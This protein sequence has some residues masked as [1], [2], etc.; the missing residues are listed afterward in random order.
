MERKEWLTCANLFYQNREEEAYQLLGQLLPQIQAYLQEL[1]QGA[2]EGNSEH[3]LMH[4]QEFIQAYQGHDQLAIS[5]WLFEES[6]DIQ[7]R[8]IEMS[9]AA[10][11]A[12]GEQLKKNEAILRAKWG[13]YFEQYQALNFEDTDKYKC[14]QTV[15]GTRIMMCLR[16]R[17]YYR[18][19]SMI[20]VDMAA[21]QYTKRYERIKD[22]STVCFFGIADGNAIRRILQNCNE[23]NEILIYEPDSDIF[24]MAM[25]NYA[26]DDIIG[27]KNVRLIVEGINAGDMRKNLEK[28]INYYN[29]NLL[30]QCVL[31]NYDIL[32]PDEGKRLIDEMIRCMKKEVFNK[33]TEY[34]RGTWMGDNLMIN[35][36]YLLKGSSLNELE[37]YLKEH[38]AGGIPAIIVSAGPS[39]D[40]NIHALARA[41]G[42]A[43]IISVDS[44]LKALMREEILPD[45]AVSI[46][47]R[48]NPELFQ[49][50][51][52]NEI[53]F[54]VEGSSLPLILER[55]RSR[56]FFMEGYG[57]DIFGEGIKQK[58][59]KKLGG[60]DTGGSVA[61]DAFSIL[62]RLGFKTIILVGQDLA[63]TE[64]KSH[65]SGFAECEANLR[66]KGSLTEVEGMHGEMLQTDIQMSYYK[67]WFETKIRLLQGE[68]QVINATEG[69]ARIQGTSEMSLQEAI[70]CYCKV[71]VDFTQML[72]NVPDA[73][74]E[75]ERQL[76]REEF[77]GIPQEVERL[78]GK[79]REGIMAYEQLINVEEIELVRIPG[80]KELLDKVE[81]A[82]HL[83]DTE[84]YLR[85]V[86]LY[87]IEAEYEATED[88]YSA[89]N[90]SISDIAKRGKHLLQGYLEG[91]YVCRERI[92]ELLIPNLEKM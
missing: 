56:L 92:N 36:P 52:I 84:Q 70:D 11:G 63:F 48:K 71:E 19:N 27:K 23:T 82:N 6:M 79:L 20:D 26:L 13:A 41:K 51:R 9:A 8:N 46:D 31:P 15:Y 7:N 18:L 85:L 34:T 25:Q 21:I 78:E 77:L 87:A 30:V 22:Y 37:R 5:D 2:A 89:E 66:S 53:P 62:Q 49:D 57:S 14:V 72:R 35:L 69:G 81:E 88:I 29:R 54:M 80:Y 44:A 28:I 50:D 43:F 45:I 58:T 3:V 75:E 90:L 33:N 1:T 59:G 74:G 32:Y 40:K 39:L 67:E 61:T 16:D 83:E 12:T 17:R 65:V 86:K 76:L 10:E 38:I 60:V 47:P 55:N 73:F 4:V 24:L 68:V 91:L 64:G 42:K